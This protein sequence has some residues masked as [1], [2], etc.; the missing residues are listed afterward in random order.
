MY[1]NKPLA[2]ML[3]TLFGMSSYE[4]SLGCSGLHEITFLILSAFELDCFDSSHTTATGSLHGWSLNLLNSPPTIQEILWWL[5][6]DSCEDKHHYITWVVALLV[7]QNEMTC[8]SQY[9]FWVKDVCTWKQAREKK[10]LR[11]KTQI[12]K[13]HLYL[14]ALKNNGC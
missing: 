7:L 12:R 13:L 1:F 5:S 3:A 6:Q 11:N 8:V 14:L 10:R 4:S 9:L 2:W